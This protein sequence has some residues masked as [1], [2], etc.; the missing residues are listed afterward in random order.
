MSWGS[1]GGAGGHERGAARPPGVRP[2]HASALGQS[3]TLRTAKRYLAATVVACVVLAV[4]VVE[5]GQTLLWPAHATARSTAA[6]KPAAAPPATPAVQADALAPYLV[7]ASTLLA[8]PKG[9]V[10]TYASPGGPPTGTAGI[11]YGYAMVLPVIAQQPGWYQVRLPQ[12]PNGST[13]WL[14]DSDVNLSS[15]PYHI[16]V[17]LSLE[18]VIVY[19]DGAPIMEFPVGIGLP[20]TPTPT[21]NFFV[22][23]HETQPQAGYGPVILD[24]SA[25][26][27]VIK[28]FE[29]LGDAIIALHGSITSAADARIGST[30]ARVS[31]GCIRMHLQDQAQL[32]IIPPGTP[33]DIIGTSP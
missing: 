20:A 19:Q 6:T 13:A 32:S 3:A 31:N 27:E 21:G 24:T 25:H 26:S 17:N 9:S 11:W 10:P 4:S 5:L 29:G 22:A 7:P 15:T 2:H 1:G 23:V 30:G 33:V 16:V 18:H 8:A 14:R 12:R 28:S